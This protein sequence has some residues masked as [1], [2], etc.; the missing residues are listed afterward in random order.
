MA[1]CGKDLAQY[2]SDQGIAFTIAVE[3][4]AQPLDPIV[5]DEIY[6]I[7]REA[8]VNAFRHSQGSKI[9]VEITFSQ[10]NMRL[11]VRDNGIGTDQETLDRGRP[12]HW[13]LSGMRERARKL[14]A[15]LSLWS[16]P[17]AGTEIELAVPAKIAF[18]PKP[19]K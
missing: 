12:G 19:R 5:R 6:Q 9:E 10:A 4:T 11:R 14:G 13:G 15:Q 18:A 16:R 7:G 2:Q 17:G 3:G 8:V 1:A